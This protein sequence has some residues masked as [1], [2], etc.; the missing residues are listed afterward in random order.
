MFV[1]F[2][3]HSK[4]PILELVRWFIGEWYLQPSLRNLSMIF[5]THMAEKEN[6]FSKTVLW[7][8]HRSCGRQTRAHACMCLCVCT[9]TNTGTQT[10][11]HRH[12]DRKTQAHRHVDRKTDRHAHS[13]TIL[14]RR[15]QFSWCKPFLDTVDEAKN[16]R[17]D[18]FCYR[19]S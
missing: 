11:T 7:P 14:K 6:R 2:L 10:Q 18:R 12:T 19:Q 5:C 17:L 8:P 3:Y 4:E 9:H 15:K 1:V 16:L 13:N